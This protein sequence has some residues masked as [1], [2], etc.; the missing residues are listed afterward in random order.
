MLARDPENVEALRLL[1]RIHW[2]QRD[3]DKLRAALERLAEAADAAGLEEDERYAL[4]QLVR[5]APDE[6]RYS[7]RLTE[8]GGVQEE[9]GGQSAFPAE[10]AVAEVPSF[11]NFALVEEETAGDGD[12]FQAE[13]ESNSVA[14]PT[15][16][17]PS[18]S[19]A[20]LN[21]AFGD[22]SH[23]A[24]DA[25]GGGSSGAVEFDFNEH[26]KGQSL[27]AGTETCCHELPCNNAMMRQEL[28]SVDFYLSQGYFDIAIDTLQMLE[29]QFGSHPEIDARR[30]RLDSATPGSV[31]AAM[32][33]ELKPEDLPAGSQEH[34]NEDLASYDFGEASTSTEKIESDPKR[35]DS[36]APMPAQRFSIP[37]WPKCLLSLKSLLK[38]KASA[39]KTTK[40]TTTW[41]RPIRDGFARRSNPG[42]SDRGYAKQTGRRNPALPAVL[43]Y[44][45][46]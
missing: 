6:N 45:G 39:T 41:A 31:E 13:F 15:L 29:G 20:E 4:T 9:A 27:R 3:M 34:E 46:P 23:L 19:F 21:E 22:A 36:A 35:L 5:L 18:A 14:E 10:P 2:W 8:L 26:G 17:D 44:A 1:V 28:E 11:E 25:N 30:Q 40:L 16:A 42:V 7:E 24:S 32:S 12:E 33:F 43:Q 37:A 38:E